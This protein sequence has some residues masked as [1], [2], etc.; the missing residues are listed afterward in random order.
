MGKMIAQLPSPDNRSSTT[1]GP[2]PAL[3]S[4]LFIGRPLWDHQLK[5]ME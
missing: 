5:L 1:G 4:R 3:A 2:K